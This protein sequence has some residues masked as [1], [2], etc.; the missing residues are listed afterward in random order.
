MRA[1]IFEYI[2]FILCASQV[3]WFWRAF[4]F[5]R[6]TFRK[7]SSALAAS[8][9]LL[10]LFFLMLAYNVGWFD[11]HTP[12]SLTSAEVFLGA[13]FTWWVACS[14]VSLILLAVFWTAVA[15]LG[16]PFWAA[17]RLRARQPSGEIP[18]PPRRHFLRAAARVV[19]AA[20]FAAGVY[21]VL[22][23]RLDL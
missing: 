20:P 9:A 8:A 21:G 17:R 2:M 15:L 6:K 12:V 5:F 13:P 3:Y 19:A 10:A 4:R 23:G 1:N 14:M 11:K 7:P 22:K 18:S 16:A